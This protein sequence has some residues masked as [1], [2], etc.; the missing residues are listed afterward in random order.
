MQ[1]AILVAVHWCDIGEARERELWEWCYVK[2][3]SWKQQ[4]IVCLIQ[5]NKWVNKWTIYHFEH[6]HNP[7]FK[8][9][10]N[11]IDVIGKPPTLARVLTSLWE[12]AWHLIFNDNNILS[13]ETE[14]THVTKIYI[15]RELLNENGNDMHLFQQSQQTQ[16]A[17]YSLIVK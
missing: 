6:S 13:I 2:I 14:R 3:D 11:V 15:D 12:H 7:R 4:R 8:K 16:D 9:Q 10:R 1:D 17:I 5:S